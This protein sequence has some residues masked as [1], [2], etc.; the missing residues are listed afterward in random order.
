MK[1][2]ICDDNPTLTEKIN[3]MLF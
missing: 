3:T 2:A 1:V